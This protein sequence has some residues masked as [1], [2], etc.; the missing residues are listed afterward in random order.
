MAYVEE[1]DL[2]KEILTRVSEESLF[3]QYIYSDFIIGKPFISPLRQDNNPSAVISNFKGRLYYKDFG[4][5]MYRGDIFSM[6]SAIWGLSFYDTLKR[7]Y[8]ELELVNKQVQYSYEKPKMITNDYEDE[9]CEILTVNRKW[10]LRDKTYWLN[11][12]DISLKELEKANIFP[13]S[14]FTIKNKRGEWTFNTNDSFV[15]E[16]RSDDGKRKIYQPFNEVKWTS[17]IP[18]S[19]FEWYLEG[20]PKT[21]II[22]KSRKDKILLDK[23]VDCHKLVLQNEKVKFTDEIIDKIKRT[24]QLVIIILD[25]DNTGV[26]ASKEW[27]NALRFDTFDWVYNITSDLKYNDPGEYAKHKELNELADIINGIVQNFDF[28]PF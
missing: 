21:L 12:Y 4:D 11:N 3:R 22:T 8:K 19:R 16:L 10:F 25:N 24:Y 2:K 5:D 17:N 20:D 7:I 27:F 28:L 9:S 13:L 23:I 6:L 1:F 15:Y 26:I 14:A 18:N